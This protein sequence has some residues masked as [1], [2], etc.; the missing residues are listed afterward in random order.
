MASRG[1]QTK[2][3]S[4]LFFGTTFLLNSSKSS[5]CPSEQSSYSDLKHSIRHNSL[6]KSAVD[7]KITIN[8]PLFHD[9]YISSEDEASS[10]SSAGLQ[11]PPSPTFSE[12][13]DFEDDL[14]DTYDGEVNNKDSLTDYGLG[15]AI[16]TYKPSDV[17]RKVSIVV[18]KPK[19]VYIT[20]PTSPTY[21]RSA[22]AITPLRHSFIQSESARPASEMHPGSYFNSYWSTFHE[23]QSVDFSSSRYSSS[24][25]SDRSD[26]SSSSSFSEASRSTAATS[27]TSEYVRPADK[28][29]APPQPPQRANAVKRQSRRLSGSFS[30]SFLAKAADGATEART[31]SKS[32]ASP[33]SPVETIRPSTAMSMRYFIPSMPDDFLRPA[34]P[35]NSR[36]TTPEPLQRKSIVP[37]MPKLQIDVP[38]VSTMPPPPESFR[39]R[40]PA[41]RKKKSISDIWFRRSVSTYV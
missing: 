11:E 27:V 12:E 33:V 14:E 1:N 39:P 4:S 22:S 35:A 41:L 6:A 19:E 23:R 16:E 38:D 26:R 5:N 40:A 15:L 31:G 10:S 9:S 24:A 28:M 37:S 8:E 7:S 32:S 30:R 20:P 13:L 18:C 34:V 3:R 2:R 25:R 29:P 36:S 21:A 17:A